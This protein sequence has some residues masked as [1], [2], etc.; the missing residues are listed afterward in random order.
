MHEKSKPLVGEKWVIRPSAPLWR[1]GICKCCFRNDNMETGEMLLLGIT[2]NWRL[3]ME[4]RINGCQHIGHVS[5]SRRQLSVE[6]IFTPGLVLPQVSNL[7][8]IAD[9]TVNAT[10]TTLP[11]IH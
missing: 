10:A 11:R 4:E 8:S 5:E 2:S 7:S 6:K 9:E 1:C 3:V